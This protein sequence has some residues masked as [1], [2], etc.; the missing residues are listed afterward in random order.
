[1]KKNILL[2]VLLIIS[3][4]KV[5]AQEKTKASVYFLCGES[6]NCTIPLDEFKKCDKKL[7]ST[8]SG[9]KIS[10]FVISIKKED[11]Q[12]IDIKI[13]GDTFSEDSIKS[14]EKLVSNNK[15]VQVNIEQVWISDNGQGRKAP[16]MTIKIK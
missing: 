3:S 4:V 15:L 10:S 7:I 2:I 14:I 6:G 16:G 12:F 5:F 13:I 8:I 1:M 11:G 9:V